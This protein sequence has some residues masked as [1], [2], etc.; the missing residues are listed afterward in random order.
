MQ[1][2][3][4]LAPSPLAPLPQVGEGRGEGYLQSIKQSIE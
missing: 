2:L 3:I 4:Q 1:E